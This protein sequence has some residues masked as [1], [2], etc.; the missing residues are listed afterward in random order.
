MAQLALSRDFLADYAKLQT[1]VRKMVDAAIDKFTGHTH[2][3]VHLE[4]LTAARD[5][6]IR[7]IRIDSFYRGVVLAPETGDTYC[8]I[9]VLP[10]DD[11]IAFAT[12]RRFTV[13]AVLGVVET[14]YEEALDA[15]APA[16]AAEAAQHNARLFDHVA[17]ADLR[18]LGIEPELLPLI[19][20]LTDE[21]LLDSLQRIMPE[22]QFDVL[23]A[24]AS[25]MTVEE[26]WEQVAAGVTVGRTAAIDTDDLTAALAR[27]TDRI[28]LVASSDELAW[29]LGQPF[30]AWR[31]FLHP[32]QRQVA[33]RPSFNGPVQVTGAAGTGKTVVA[34]HR[35][36]HL[37]SR[38]E[39][40]GERPP[41][42][43]TTYTT[44]LA[45][46][47]SGALD[48]LISDAAVRARAEVI[49]IDKI[50]YRL[51]Q[52]KLGRKPV[53]ATGGQIT[54]AWKRAAEHVGAPVSAS[55][56]AAEWEQVVLAQGATT[57]E[58]YLTCPRRGR[59]VRLSPAQKAE[60]WQCVARFTEELRDRGLW[61]FLEL[62]QIA[63]GAATQSGPLY[64][65]VVVDE[66]QDLHP[67]QWRL[68][69]ALAAEGPDDLF[70][71]GDPHQRIYDNRVS[72]RS[73][74]VNVSGRSKRL[75]VCY[76]TTSEILS[77]ATRL[78]DGEQVDDLDG[79]DDPLTGFRSLLHGNWPAQFAFPHRA[80]ELSALTEQV[81]QWVADGVEPQDI[82]VSGRTSALVDEAIAA[83]RAAGME[84]SA[85]ADGGPAGV[86]VGTMH[87]LKGLE[88][89]CT[90]LIGVD[91]QNVPL[92]ASVADAAEEPERHT[93]DL[94]RERCLLFVAATRSREALYVSHTGTPSP[95]LP[96]HRV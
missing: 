6:R 60:V 73:L 87:R 34:L 76:R 36:R 19:R 24:L 43:L 75:T 84:A 2:A 14:R 83:L 22:A 78:L 8:L 3:G 59:G 77:W 69:R 46:N 38:A 25:G 91:D 48:T 52:E 79:Q 85:L 62:A 61:T 28:A 51:A 86:K 40:D 17:D 94:Q 80:A 47:L 5:R 58:T 7:T 23:V 20:V 32:L 44:T 10:H 65:H 89:R 72:L 9:A 15:L 37:A 11:A 31:T 53:M 63:A 13:N 56:L 30:A 45:Q 4:K 68:I 35:V 1:P 81:V 74:G 64:R 18:R 88:F 67:A 95:F 12:T 90:A 29:I 54:V 93:A 92:P 82:A 57:L 42:L 26:T 71:V 55:F 16:L 96:I 49:N 70:I 41:V 27:T 50:A 66:A 33:Y 39:P 21:R